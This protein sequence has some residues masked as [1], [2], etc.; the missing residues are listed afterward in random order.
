VPPAPAP[1]TA[2]PGGSGRSPRAAPFVRLP[3][4]LRARHGKVK[5]Q[6][7]C[8]QAERCRGRLSL[9]RLRA[10]LLTGSRTLSIRA[11]RAATFTLKLRRKRLGSARR[12]RVRIAFAGRDA[13]GAK[14]KVTRTA[15]LRRR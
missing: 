10:R 7:R 11:A 13:S 15:T 3:A 6:V 12:V 8:L 5:L 4:R 9:R 1:A 14:R 2:V